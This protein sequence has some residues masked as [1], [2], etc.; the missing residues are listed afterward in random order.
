VKISVSLK[1]KERRGKIAQNY[2]DFRSRNQNKNS[3]FRFLVPRKN[4]KGEIRGLTRIRC[5]ALVGEPPNAASSQNHLSDLQDADRAH[6]RTWPSETVSP[7]MQSLWTT[8]ALTP[9]AMPQEI[10]H[11]IFPVLNDVW[12]KLIE[13][14]DEDDACTH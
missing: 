10:A 5:A 1:R 14:D 12:P 11:L 8:Q 3:G 2:S 7:R 13:R 9:S 6:R 4:K